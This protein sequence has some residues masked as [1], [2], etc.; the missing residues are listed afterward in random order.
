MHPPDCDPPRWSDLAADSADP[1][2]AA[3]G[4]A[5]RREPPPSITDAALARIGRSVFAAAQP[6]R[7]AWL[8]IRTAVLVALVLAASGGV[9]GAA[10]LVWRA[11]AREP[12]TLTVPAN[13]RAT[14]TG[15]HRRR[16]TIV[17]PATLAIDPPASRGSGSAPAPDIVLESG[18]LTIEAGGETLS[19]RSG[20]LTVGIPGDGAAEISAGVNGEPAVKAL[21]GA[22]RVRRADGA[23]T[24]LSAAPA[25]APATPPGEAVEDPPS[26]S[27]E[28]P[29]KAPA[30]VP[31]PEAR[32]LESAK[33]AD[34]PLPPSPLVHRPAMIA[35]VPLAPA[36][37]ATLSPPPAEAPPA[38]PT[39]A[40][41]L[42]IAFR[43]LRAD[44][45]PAAALDALDAHDRAFPTGWLRPE[46]DLARA[47][48]LLALGRPDE[49][50]P[51]LEKSTDAVTRSVRLTRGELFAQ[52]SRC[53][54]AVDDFTD[55]LR[56]RADDELGE[57]A[58]AGRAACRLRA[59]RGEAARQDLERYLRLFPRGPH[60]D[61]A[62]RLL[63][64]R[65]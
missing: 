33:A 30:S 24:L 14:I 36:L 25:G 2:D 49:A 44:G 13:N 26:V 18:K 52:A 41:A 51:L 42:A 20:E 3:I 62:R 11:P 22:P 61:E 40:A 23:E 4:C 6:Q 10:R 19:V 29:D 12:Q 21:S 65:Q 32:R 1:D 58:L 8:V 38:T 43:K 5:F 16:L 17:G 34:R 59:G 9:V 7:R 56:A 31:E 39:E 60:A 48:A 57:R 64:S 37:A 35:P 55:V 53:P 63:T 27:L 54:R 46:A 15:R 28:I 50:L 47:E 45:D